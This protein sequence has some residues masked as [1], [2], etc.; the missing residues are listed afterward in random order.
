MTTVRNNVVIAKANAPTIKN[1][2]IYSVE[3]LQSIK[4]QAELHSSLYCSGVPNNHGA[5]F[6]SDI[7]YQPKNF[8]VVDN[9]LLCD[10]HRLKVNEHIDTV[11]LQVYFHVY[12]EGNINKKNQITDFLLLGILTYNE[13]VYS[14]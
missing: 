8:R 6:L 7:C 4:T 2:H 10:M 13:P 14:E 1:G 9:C 11:D 12:G 5:L 3:I